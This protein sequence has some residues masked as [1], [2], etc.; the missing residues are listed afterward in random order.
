MCAIAG[1]IGLVADDRICRKMLE[2]MK[3]RGPDD[4]GIY[5]Q[6]LCTL[7]HTRLAIVDPEG[8]RQPMVLEWAGETYV[9]VYN[10]RKATNYGQGNSHQSIS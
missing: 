3:R 10:R 1:M 4:K 8:G 9:L 7:L 5:Q 6:G 2:T